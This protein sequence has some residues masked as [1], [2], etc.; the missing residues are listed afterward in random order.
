MPGLVKVG[1][2]CSPP[3]ERLPELQTT[4]VPTPFIL[5]AC[6]RVINAAKAEQRVHA[7]LVKWRQS[8]NREFFEISLGDALA[9]CLPSIHE[10]LAT[11]FI[12]SA[13]MFQRIPS[14]EESVL[15]FITQQTQK[16]RRPERDEIRRHFKFSQIKSDYVL[17][18]LIKR[19]FVREATEKRESSDPMSYASWKV[20]AMKLEHAGIQ[21]LLD[22]GLITTADL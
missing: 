9:Q 19:K 16:R 13:T 5:E 15:L 3:S 22:N 11:T 6:I 1:V 12:G 10:F 14:E 4:G 17:G 8:S 18:A 7:A 21:Y 20:K 2:T